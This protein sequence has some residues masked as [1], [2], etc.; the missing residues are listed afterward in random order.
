MWQVLAG[1]LLVGLRHV[2]D[3]DDLDPQSL[4]HLRE[5][6]TTSEVEY[7]DGTGRVWRFLPQDSIDGDPPAGYERDDL[8]QYLT[9]EGIYL[10]LIN[11]RGANGWQLI[12]IHNDVA[13]FDEQG[14]LGELRDRRLLGEPLHAEV[15]RVHP[16]HHAL[17]E[18]GGLPSQRVECH[19]AI[20]H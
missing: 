19:T 9:P 18:A 2:R 14:R 6:P 5:I 16:Q 7:H 8:G 10:R 15:R 13:V 12:G 1:E 4:A 11:N 17:P 20:K 3:L